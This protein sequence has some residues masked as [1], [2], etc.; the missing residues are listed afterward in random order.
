MTNGGVDFE[1]DRPAA[2]GQLLDAENDAWRKRQCVDK[3]WWKNINFA[4][5]IPEA[6]HARQGCGLFATIAREEQFG[7]AKRASL[8][9]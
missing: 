3:G 5:K 2:I 6:T 4:Q 7:E 1:A 9:W 8:S